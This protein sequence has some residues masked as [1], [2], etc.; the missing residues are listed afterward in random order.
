MERIDLEPDSW[1][2][3]GPDTMAKFNDKPNWKPKNGALNHK[4]FKW[5]RNLFENDMKKLAEHILNCPDQKRKF[6]YP[7]VTIK[8]ISFV[9]PSCYTAKDWKERRKRKFLLKRELHLLN[10][11]LGLLNLSGD[12]QPDSWKAFKE[13]YNVTRAMMNVLLE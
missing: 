5:L 10:H 3:D 6:E 1:G 11:E 2:I 8:I 7:K 4:F 13:E 9:L 12:L